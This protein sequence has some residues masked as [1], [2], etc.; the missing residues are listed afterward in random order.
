MPKGRGAFIFCPWIREQ[1]REHSYVSCRS[2]LFL[3]TEWFLQ[4]R[5]LDLLLQKKFYFLLVLVIT[6]FTLSTLSYWNFTSSLILKKIPSLLLITKL[7]PTRFL[8]LFTLNQKIDSYK[9]SESI[10]FLAVWTCLTYVILVKKVSLI[11]CKRECVELIEE[12]LEQ[13]I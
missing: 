12:S 1:L 7:I 10:L 4:D 6:E 8:N 9:I 3:I 11:G 5:S 2:I 13:D